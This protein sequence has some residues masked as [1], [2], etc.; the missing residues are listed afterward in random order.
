MGNA[1]AT[2]GM[3]GMTVLVIILSVALIILGVVII[4]LSLQINKM[5][6][7]SEETERKYQRKVDVV[8]ES[9]DDCKA[10]MREVQLQ[11]EEA[12]ENAKNYKAQRDFLMNSKKSQEE[13]QR[14]DE[15]AEAE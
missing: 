7:E 4:L 11:K 14:S 9:L 15:E 6:K 8:K 2:L 1:I 13:T 5:V 3:Q 12:E 10:Q